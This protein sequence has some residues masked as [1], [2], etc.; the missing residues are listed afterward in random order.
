MMLESRPSKRVTE[1]TKCSKLKNGKEVGVKK[2]D[3][4]Q[5]G[6]SVKY[7][8]VKVWERSEKRSFH[9]PWIQPGAITA[10]DRRGDWR[11]HTGNPVLQR[12]VP[13]RPQL[14]ALS[15]ERKKKSLTVKRLIKSHFLFY[16]ITFVFPLKT[17]GGGGSRLVVRC[18]LEKRNLKPP[19][20]HLLLSSWFWKLQ[21][22]SK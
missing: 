21:A 7:R 19:S 14:L 11:L 1:K 4:R 20:L 10:I 13:T 12:N 17:I 22:S 2:R 3:K 16:E 18:A 15:E 8:D 6:I 5:S 9:F